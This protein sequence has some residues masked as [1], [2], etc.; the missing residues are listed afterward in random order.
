MRGRQITSSDLDELKSVFLDLGFGTEADIDRIA[1]EHEGF[2]LFL[3]SI[4]GLTRETAVRAFDAFQQG[5]SL[6][7]A[8]YNFIELI[9]DS[10]TK[11]GYL[12][13]G[14]LYD[15]PFRRHGDPDIVFRKSSDVDV[16][17]DVLKHLK[18]TAVPTDA[19]AG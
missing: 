5:R 4:T 14:E 1:E 9:I 16:I 19:E 13:V 17:A 2:G 11:N 8:E 18:K 12:D 6:T 10:L 7:P 3:R 15:P